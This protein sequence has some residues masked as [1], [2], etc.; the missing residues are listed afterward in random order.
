MATYQLVPTPAWN[1]NTPLGSG[2]IAPLAEVAHYLS[3]HPGSTVPDIAHALGILPS[4][5]E[6]CLTKLVVAGIVNQA[7]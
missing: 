1:P 5:V 6:V 2:E 3:S 7:A 4:D